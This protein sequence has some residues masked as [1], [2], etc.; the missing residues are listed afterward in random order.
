[1]RWR[2]EL[3][4]VPLVAAALAGCGENGERVFTL[5]E[6]VDEVNAEGAG[7][8]VGPVITTSE[9]GVEVR[10]LT[11]TGETLSPTGSARDT[12]EPHGGNGAILVLENA[13]LAETELDRCQPA[14][15]L[16][17]FRAANVVIRFEDMLP[18]D[19]ARISIAVQGLA[20]E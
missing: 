7:V 16:T 11:L 9:D 5:D 4:A 1:M 10:S 12:E 8:E 17:C 14:P 2:S 13:E 18:E 15:A 19:Q 6:F 3:A 20:S